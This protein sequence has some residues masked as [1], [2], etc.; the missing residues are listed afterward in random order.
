MQPD[1]M[2]CAWCS[3]RYNPADSPTLGL[4]WACAYEDRLCQEEH[5]RLN[6]KLD[7]TETW[8]VHPFANIQPI[9]GRILARRPSKATW[10]RDLE[11]L[12]STPLTRSGY[13]RTF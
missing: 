3:C 11:D 13:F 10:F 5:D 4:C 6:E 7:A 2:I 9:K 8:E 12:L 1:D